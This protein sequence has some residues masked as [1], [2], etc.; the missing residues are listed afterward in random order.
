MSDDAG[1]QTSLD[2][3]V[4]EY[5]GEES[6]E[7][8][9]AG[10]LQEIDESPIE[11]WELRR[12]G[13]V[14]SLE[15]GENLT[16]DERD[17]GQY[18]VY[19][20]NGRVGSHSESY[21]D[22]S[23]IIIGRKGSI[24]EAEFSEEPFYPID[25]TYY[26]SQEETD[27]NLRFVYYLLENV[28]LSR[29][30]AASAI[31]GLN[32]N[33]VYSLKGLVPSLSEQRKI[34]SILYNVDQSIQKTEQIIKRCR[35]L[36]SGLLQSVFHEYKDEDTK[37]VGRLGKVPTTWEVVSLSEVTEVTMGNSPKS[38]YYNSEKDGLPFYQ[39]ADEFG[40]RSPTPDRWCSNPKK[41]GKTGD[42]LLNIRS[43]TN[44]GK[45]NQ[46]PHKCCIGR[47]LAAITPSTE[48][49]GDFLY[50]HLRERESYVNAI[51]SGST[52]DSVNSKEVESL[53]ITLP[54]LDT[55]EEIASMLNNVQDTILKEKD[56]IEQY[57]RLKRG[58]MQDLLSGEVRTT[59]EDINVLPEVEKYG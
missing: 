2:E 59:D 53:K 40:E 34:A 35:Q 33:D 30:N 11:G 49:D 21:V 27:E 1:Q 57:T 43:H 12:L 26:I 17:G 4:D 28:Q 15:Y 9:D 20:S 58:L 29:L 16:E 50:H 56:A 45:V 7:K 31:P 44:V 46:A 37:K 10:K 38:E 42:T 47:G 24:G 51:A 48:I 41:I 5:T 25:T 8:V 13:D 54:P 3:A 55:Q 23:G 19:G 39:G 52:F 36:Y 32:R 6:S 14:F 22:D 18:P